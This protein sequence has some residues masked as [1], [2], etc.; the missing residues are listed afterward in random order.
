M[1]KGVWRSMVAG[2]GW[3]VFGPR[4]P[5]KVLAD[6]VA[7]PSVWRLGGAPMPNEMVYRLRVLTIGIESLT[8][9]GFCWAPTQT[10]KRTSDALRMR[11]WQYEWRDM[12]LWTGLN[13]TKKLKMQKL[14]PVDEILY[15][16]RRSLWIETKLDGMEGFRVSSFIA[17]GG[18][19]DLY[20]SFATCR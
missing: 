14:I 5:A 4:A 9:E 18:L 17:Q 11:Q 13:T 3:K 20:T 8:L 16:W 10:R 15:G 19:R 7:I 6:P 12:L 2:V 1:K